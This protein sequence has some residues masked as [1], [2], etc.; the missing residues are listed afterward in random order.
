MTRVNNPTPVVLTLV[1]LRTPSH[2]LTVEDPKELFLM[3]AIF[4][5]TACIRNQNG[6]IFEKND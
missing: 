6:V 5:G 2:S 3:W 4:D 1:T